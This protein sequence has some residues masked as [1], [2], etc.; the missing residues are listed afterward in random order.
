[1]PSC[2]LRLLLLCLLVLLWISPTAGIDTLVVGMGRFISREGWT[3]IEESSRLLQVS[4][5]SLWTWEEGPGGDLTRGIAA[6]EGGLYAIG[7]VSGL[8]AE[9]TVVYD[10]DPGTAF[11]PDAVPY[12]TRT[13]PLVIDLGGAFRIGRIRFFPRLDLKHQQRFLQEFTLS[14][15]LERARDYE[16]LKAYFAANPNTEPLVD[17]SFPPRDAR[18]LMLEPTVNRGWEIAEFEIYTDGGRPVGEFTSKPLLL[19]ST[20]RQT[21]GKVRYEAGDITRLPVQVQ[22]RTGPDS[23]PTLYFLNFGGELV[24]VEQNEWAGAVS[25]LKGPVLANPAWS[26]WQNLEEGR[27]RSPGGVRYLQFRVRLSEP[28][29]TLRRL[30]FEYSSPPLASDLAAEINPTLVKA[31]EETE[32]TLSLEIHLDSRRTVPDTGF[33]QLQ[34]R[35]QAQVVAV[36]K[37]MVDDREVLFSFSR[38][39]GEGITIDLP[40]RIDQNGS[41]VQVLFSAVIFRDFTRFEV[42]AVDRRRS[43][44][45]IPETAYQIAR[46]ED[47]EPATVGGSLAVQLVKKR[48]SLPLIIDLTMSPVFT[49]NGDGINDLFALSYTL[50]TLLRPARVSLSIFDLRGDLQARIDADPQEMG[51]RTME[52]DG[53]GHSGE[54]VPPG[55]YLYQLRVDADEGAVY[56]QGMMGVA[57]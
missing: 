27:V 32:F 1:M 42:R 24:E 13:T 35:T 34:V 21:W 52:W 19:R 56:R 50:L 7:A 51:Y 2:R 46:P 48:A 4:R 49:P 44:S 9:G 53:R 15:S 20:S 40:H 16:Q 47:V 12:V 33:R 30:I 18:Y 54:R 26:S 3:H 5:D 55:L 8:L 31:G 25:G 57:Y 39:P 17:L 22:T 38:Q 37:V 11:D 43:D 29:T 45:G 28:G 41:F 6:R 23:K 14:T 10:G 36:E